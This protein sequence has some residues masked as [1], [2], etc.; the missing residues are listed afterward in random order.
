M[1]GLGGG[2]GFLQSSD[3]HSSG[4]E[5]AYEMKPAKEEAHENN[6]PPPCFF[7]VLTQ[8]HSVNLLFPSC[9]LDFQTSD[10]V[11]LTSKKA[12]CSLPRSFLLSS[13][14][15]ADFSLWKGKKMTSQE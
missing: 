13:A 8:F 1:G 9:V 5:Q 4:P 10:R 12:S 2:G 3:I 14:I 15:Q 6:G 7:L 11:D